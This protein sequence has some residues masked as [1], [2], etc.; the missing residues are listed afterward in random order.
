MSSTKQLLKKLK[1]DVE[2]YTP[3]S[4]IVG[5]VFGLVEGFES[6]HDFHQNYGRKTIGDCYQFCKKTQQYKKVNKP[7]TQLLVASALPF[8][9]T[10]RV[11]APWGGRSGAK[12][13]SVIRILV[14]LSRVKTIKIFCLRHIAK[15]LKESVC[16]EIIDVIDGMGHGDEYKFIDREFTNISSGSRFIFG[17]IKGNIR[18]I[19]GTYGVDVCWIDEAAGL[20]EKEYEIIAN[21]IRKDHSEIWLTWNPEFETD[22]VETRFRHNK[23]LPDFEKCWQMPYWENPLF[24]NVS[25]AGMLKQAKV[26]LKLY[27]HIWEGEYYQN[28]AEMIK[29][30]WWGFFTDFTNAL[31]QCRLIFI[32][33]DT[34][35]TKNPLNDPSVACVWGYTVEGKLLLLAMYRAFKEF[36]PLL[37]DILNLYDKWDLRDRGIKFKGIYIEAKA[38]GLSLVQSIKSKGK[39]ARAW[40]PAHYKYPIDKVGRVNESAEFVMDQHVLLPDHTLGG[41]HAFSKQ[42]ID[43]CSNFTDDDTHNFDDIVDNLTMA[44]SIARILR[45]TLTLKKR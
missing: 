30:E 38:T 32:T 33:A 5:E 4:Q 14:D 16:D 2:K 34:A 37:K 39:I 18:M 25:L 36:P 41:E 9:L 43:E 28:D 12:T 17:G 15:S 40:M 42:M 1:Q 45:K 35:Y 19:K 20:I 21:T 7:H 24:P 13:Q 27:Q 11:K 44:I 6:P 3:A 31:A 23:D 26:N 8:L 29:R 10:S 22:F